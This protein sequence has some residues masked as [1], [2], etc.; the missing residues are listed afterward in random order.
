MNLSNAKINSG[1]LNNKVPVNSLNFIFFLLFLGIFFVANFD[2]HSSNKPDPIANGSKRI[3]LQMMNGDGSEGGESA[4]S[5]PKTANLGHL[6]PL[7][8]FNVTENEL[9]R[10]FI[11][12]IRQ[13][14]VRDI[15]RIGVYFEPSRNGNYPL[16]HVI[17]VPEFTTFPHGYVPSGTINDDFERVLAQKK[18]RQ[19]ILT[20]RLNNEGQITETNASSK[21]ISR[22]IFLD[23]FRRQNWYYLA[24]PEELLTR[25]EADQ[26]KSGEYE[27]PSLAE[28]NAVLLFLVALQKAVV[29]SPELNKIGIKG[30]NRLAHENGNA[31]NRMMEIFARA[32][33]TLGKEY[34]FF[35][36]AHADKTI[37]T[38]APNLVSISSASEGH[39]TFNY[40]Y[41]GYFGRGQPGGVTY[42]DQTRPIRRLLRFRF[43]QTFI[44]DGPVSWTGIQ[45][46]RH[47][48]DR[49]YDTFEIT[50][51]TK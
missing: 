15:Q 2:A 13:G 17:Y 50:D 39:L 44:Y 6:E 27:N 38:P 4:A 41:T 1:R 21:A 20:F 14:D 7:N 37:P 34:G 47:Y 36:N 48:I 11:H 28:A 49:A 25:R 5:R 30:L 40:E 10:K 33:L 26:I 45:L 12:L 16:V 51:V 23:H 3:C 18:V 19:H 31:E 9:I 8:G 42:P 22:K 32:D 29:H 35:A 46:P 43:S 24:S